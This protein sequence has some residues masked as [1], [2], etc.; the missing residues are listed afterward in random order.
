MK[1]LITGATGFIGS[2]LAERLAAEG[3]DVRILCRETSNRRWI[4][5]IGAEIVVG[6]MSNVESLHRA[7][8]DVDYVYHIAGVVAS[9]DREGF[10]RGNVESTRNLL[11]AVAEVNPGLQRFVHSSSQAAVGPAPSAENPADESWPLRPITTYGESKAAAE[12]VVREF[13]DRLPVTIV[14]PPAVYGPRDVGIYTFFQ[15]A[16][17]GIAPLIGSDRKL[18]SLVHVDDLVSGF[19]LAG[20]KEAGVGQTY[21]ISSEELYDWR[22]VGN[23]TARILGRK[24]PLYLSIPHPV[25]HAVAALSGSLGRFRKTPPILDRE[26]GRDITQPFWICSVEKARNELGYRQQTSIEEGVRQTVEWYREHG[27]L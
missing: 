27:W 23:V 16:A 20:T 5:H 25:V 12:E 3:T 1:A 10:F 22:Q 14:R 8:E 24:R 7:V 15:V 11:Q 18:V 13:S 26:K 21:F 9:R 4:D 2:H 19:I 17:R 6:S